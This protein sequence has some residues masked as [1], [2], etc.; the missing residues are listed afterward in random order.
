MNL[1]LYVDDTVDSRQIDLT[2]RY[3][4]GT[5]RNPLDLLADKESDWLSY[6]PAHTSHMLSN[7]S[8]NTSK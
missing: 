6:L 7:Q 1:K 3:L 2:H 8:S 5:N 4:T